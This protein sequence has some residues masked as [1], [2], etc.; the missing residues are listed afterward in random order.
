MKRTLSITS[1]YLRLARLDYERNDRPL[2]FEERL[3]ELIATGRHKAVDD[4][5]NV[6]PLGNP[7]PT[8]QGDVAIPTDEWPARKKIDV[9][10]DTDVD[11]LL[12]ASMQ[13]INDWLNVALQEDFTSPARQSRW[14]WFRKDTTLYNPLDDVR[15]QLVSLRLT[16]A[17]S[18]LLS[19]PFVTFF[20]VTGAYWK[21]GLLL[22]IALAVIIYNVWRAK[23]MSFTN[24]EYN[25]VFTI[26][27]YGTFA[28]SVVNKTSLRQEL[29]HLQ[30][31][32]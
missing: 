27:V 23:N 5:V 14:S 18:W 19:I 24:K 7:S 12:K 10:I 28:N 4:Q 13:D 17:V 15:L 26:P 1:L 20:V 3:I 31:G 32:R 21:A 6:L 8:R 25:E 29:T 22:S 9:T 30:T 2:S 16:R 11:W